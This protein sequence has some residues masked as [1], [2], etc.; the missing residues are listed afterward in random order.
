MIDCVYASPEACRAAN[1]ANRT[2]YRKREVLSITQK[3]EG[4][5]CEEARFLLESAE[6]ELKILLYTGWITEQPGPDAMC[7]CFATEEEWRQKIQEIEALIPVLKASK[8]H[9]SLQ[10]QLASRALL[11]MSLSGPP[12]PNGCPFHYPKPVS[13]Y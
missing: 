10:H 6:Q 8:E 7:L 11:I 9:H 13:A 4:F 5:L 12:G 2:Y 1:E 3:R